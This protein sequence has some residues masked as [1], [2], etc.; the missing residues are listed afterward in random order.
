[1]ILWHKEVVEVVNRNR[2]M[3]FTL[4]VVLVTLLCHLQVGYICLNTGAKKLEER[5][6]RNCKY[7]MKDFK[8]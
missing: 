1:M 2:E 8:S 3:F 5:A 7:I 4:H 6:E